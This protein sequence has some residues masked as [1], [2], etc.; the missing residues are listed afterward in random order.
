MPQEKLHATRNDLAE[1][2]R[3]AMVEL[4]NRQLADTIDLRLQAKQAHWNVKGPQ[5]IALHELFD[6][7]YEEVG[8]FEDTIAERAV[9][10]GGVALGT[11]QAVG[12]ATRVAP[13]PLDLASGH[14]HIS[15]LATAVGAVASSTRAAIDEAAESADADTADVFTEVSRG[16]DKLLWLIEAHEHSKD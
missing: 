16:L 4:L 10:L 11:V 2:T 7:A 13:Y 12:R 14:G 5:F 9:Q 15:A 8:E 3:R 1:S 6:R